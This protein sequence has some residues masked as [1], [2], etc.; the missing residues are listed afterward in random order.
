MRLLEF[1][2]QGLRYLLVEHWPITLAAVLGLVAVYVLLPKPRR[3]PV[4]LGV[5]AA[6]LA[7]VVAGVFVVRAGEVSVE[8]V[9]F[10]LFAG[11]AVVFGGLLVTQ[12]NPARAAL[13]FAMVILATCGLFLLQ[14]ATF[15]MAAT[16]IVYAGAIIVTFLF[17][18]MLAQ[19]EG[20]SDADARSREP[21]L[22]SFTGFLLL[23][24]LLF[25]LK[26]TYDADAAA[27]AGR[28]GEAVRQVRDLR[29]RL[30]DPEQAPPSREELSRELEG[31]R[32]FL[33]KDF[34]AAISDERKNPRRGKKPLYDA[35]DNALFEIPRLPLRAEDARPDLR[36]LA[37]RL[38]DVWDLALQQ[39]GFLRPETDQATK[40]EEGRTVVVRRPA[41]QL[42]ELSGPASSRPAGELRR[43]EHGRPHLPAEN[44]AHLGRSL[45]SDYL[46]AVEV[47][48]LLLLVAA[49]GA[50]AIAQRRPPVPP[51]AG[52]PDQE[53][54]R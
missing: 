40:D 8:T 10:Y 9:L 36:G 51:A 52:Q 17:V 42:S 31:V 32:E 54:N 53:P 11:I 49:V 3:M 44:T 22:A 24:T 5:A 6:A 37:D 29:R 25:V 34:L 47:A 4:L 20:R 33:E 16:I 41:P 39:Q 12:Q 26:G 30:A 43:D 48:G 46:L 14:A 13:S 15:L 27:W 28:A 7:L 23:G 19:P 18:I 35:I 21:F 2:S 50:I 45:F 1:L 38:N